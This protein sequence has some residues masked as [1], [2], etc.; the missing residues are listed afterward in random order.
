MSRNESMNNDRVSMLRLYDYNTPYIT[1][2]YSIKHI[3]KNITYSHRRVKNN[4]PI[5]KPLKTCLQ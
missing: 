3:C 2:D 1:I 5:H 4:L